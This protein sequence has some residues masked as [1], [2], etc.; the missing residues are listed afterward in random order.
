MFVS[1][2]R[3]A[4]AYRATTVSD[5]RTGRDRDCPMTSNEIST[6]S[7]ARPANHSGPLHTDVSVKYLHNGHWTCEVNK[8]LSHSV[9]LLYGVS[10][11]IERCDRG[12]SDSN[13]EDGE[14]C[15]HN[16]YCLYYKMH[17][18]AWVYVH[19]NYLVISD[20]FQNLCIRIIFQCFSFMEL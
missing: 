9:Y 16:L 8:F 10:K 18:R 11:Y 19:N 13:L 2:A 7:S 1:R 15:Y 6:A 3:R 5:N 12:V 14:H 20:R 4:S 17:A